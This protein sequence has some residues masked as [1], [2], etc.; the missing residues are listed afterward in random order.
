MVD[1]L[2]VDVEVGMR[3]APAVHPVENDGIEG[4]LAAQVLQ[5][6]VQAV[7]QVDAIQLRRVFE[8][9]VLWPQ[10]MIEVGVLTDEGQAVDVVLHFEL[11]DVGVVAVA[12]GVC[13]RI[14][15][16]ENFPADF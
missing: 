6:V 4:R 12:W 14:P 15:I 13:K 3:G 16:Y 5:E 10:V 8:S 7:G 2:A 9:R 11:P 1:T